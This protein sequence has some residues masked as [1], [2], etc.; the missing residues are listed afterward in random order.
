[1][2]SLALDTSTRRQSVALASD[3]HLMARICLGVASRHSETLI[4]AIDLTLSA[5]GLGSAE[6]DAVVVTTGP[7]SF[8]GLRVGMATAKGLV[9]GTSVP[10][11]GVSTLHALAEALVEQEGVEQP[12]TVCALMEAGRGE[13]Y[14]GLFRVPRGSEGPWRTVPAAAECA[15]RPA[16]ALAGLEAG[17]LV[18]GD[19]SQR[20]EGPE[21]EI[22]AGVRFARSVPVLADTL[23]LRVESLARSGGVPRDL[24][25]PNYIRL[26][27]ALRP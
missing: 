10:L 2:A 17:T 3:D 15:C 22:P 19:G 24:L 21:A 4:P 27:D 26:P 5:A 6:L 8:T 9:M 18:G 7:G 11:L 12:R 1:M 13:L 14:R 16:E 20:F 25:A 23:A